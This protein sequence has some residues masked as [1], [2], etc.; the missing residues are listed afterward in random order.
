[1]TKIIVHFDKAGK[2]IATSRFV[3]GAIEA[4]RFGLVAGEYD[5]CVRHSR[6]GDDEALAAL[7]GEREPLMTEAEAIHALASKIAAPY[8]IDAKGNVVAVAVRFAVADAA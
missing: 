6:K 4:A 7:I 1:M 8:E 2:E 3:P 5:A